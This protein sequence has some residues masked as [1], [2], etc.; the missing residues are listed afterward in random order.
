MANTPD[1]VEMG[2]NTRLLSLVEITPIY[3]A[4]IDEMAINY[5]VTY[6]R[7]NVS[8]LADNC[9][10]GLTTVAYAEQ[11]QGNRFSNAYATRSA[12]WLTYLDCLNN[13]AS[14]VR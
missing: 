1:Y 12:D 13:G 3:A 14:E 5:V 9:W 10:T 11:R 2:R 4:Y 7:G 8:N 6:S